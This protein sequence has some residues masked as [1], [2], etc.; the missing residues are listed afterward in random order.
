M[1]MQPVLYWP[2][3]VHSGLVGGG[4]RIGRPGGEGPKRGIE[5]NRVR[6]RVAVV[7]ASGYAGAELISLLAHHPGVAELHVISRQHAGEPVG[8][9][10]PHLVHREDLLFE[11]LAP[12][13]LAASVDCIFGSTP[14]GAARE[15]AVPAVRHGVRYI[16]LGADF[17]LHDPDL[18]PRY[19]KFSHEGEALSLLGEAVY[20][21]P[22]VHRE[23]IKQARVVANPGCYPTAVLLGL[24]PLLRHGLV[25]RDGR[26]VQVAALSGVS[27]AGATP[28]AGYH[29]PEMTENARPYQVATHRHTPEMEQEAAA[30]AGYAVPFTFVPHLI[31]A[32]R[33]ILA[34]C[35]VPLEEPLKAARALELY[36]ETYRGERFVR[37]LGEE[38]LPQIK[39]VAG[40]NFCDVTVRM[41]AD[42]KTAVVLAAIDNLRKGAAGQAVQNFNLMFGWPE[43]TA[44][45]GYPLFP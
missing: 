2:Q 26:A 20:G 29:F 27:G 44:L 10:W 22:E 41:A 35:F 45:T 5:L 39:A 7:G 14:A 15:L 3:R 19:Y 23:E 30:L 4:S 8:K 33:G 11:P 9:V 1:I 21:L 37:V 43:E 40:S 17:R 18:Y 25:A 16:D 12:E 31:P 28:A 38:A 13:E 6:V 32:S 36:R 42:G 34:T 24:A